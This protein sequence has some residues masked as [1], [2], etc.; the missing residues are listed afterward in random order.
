MIQ[1]S[2]LIPSIPSRF[3]RAKAL[4]EKLLAMVGDKQIEVLMLT[5]NKKRTI[6]EKR[7]SLKNASNGKYFMFV[8]DDDDLLELDD[9]YNATFEDV[10]VITFKQLC[11]NEDK[12]TFVIT[13]GLGNEVEHKNIRGRYLDCKRPPFHICAWN[14]KFRDYKY[15]PVNYAE[16]WGWLDQVLPLA[17]SEIHIPK[18]IHSYNFDPNVTEASTESNIVWKNPNQTPELIIP[19]QLKQ[20]KMVTETGKTRAIVNLVTNNP[21]YLNCQKRLEQSALNN[22]DKSF[23]FFCFQNESQ[24]GLSFTLR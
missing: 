17:K 2:I 20:Y 8:D 9:L 11:L 21:N 23:D 16:D 18:I 7:D 5:D 10:D 13:F 24:V 14:Q 6:G 12:T 15:P 22:E 4:Y 3:G 1:L 19:N